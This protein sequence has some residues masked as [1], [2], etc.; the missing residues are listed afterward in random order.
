MKGIIIYQ[1]KYGA[2]KQYAQWLAEAT[3]LNTRRADATSGPD[4]A[5]YELIV[6]GSSVY[7]GKLQ[8]S[9]WVKKN[10]EYLYGKKLFLFQVAGTP[11]SETGK[12]DSYNLASLPKDLYNSCQFYYLGGRMQLAVLSRWDRF[13]L[14]MGARMT[15]YKKGATTILEEYDHVSKD[16]LNTL[17]RDIKKTLAEKPGITIFSS[18][19]PNYASFPG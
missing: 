18:N 13:T 10:R 7:V 12:R 9:N 14:R 17:I 8:V 5:G 19:N 15:R 4:L 3:G 16:Q 2:T 11:P 6:I 1:G